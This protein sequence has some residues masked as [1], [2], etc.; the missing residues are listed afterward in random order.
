ML[1]K[2]VKE[3][4]KKKVMIV[5][6]KRLTVYLCRGEASKNVK[7]GYVQKFEYLGKCFDAS[8][9]L[10][11]KYLSESQQSINNWENVRTKNRMLYCYVI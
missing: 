4:K 9:I 3:K 7:F 11:V 2:L 1:E 5:S 8:R 6:C 10:I